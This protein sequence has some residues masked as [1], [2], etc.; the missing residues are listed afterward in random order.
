MIIFEEGSYM[1]N[2]YEDCYP[3]IDYTKALEHEKK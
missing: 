2:P 1:G 3:D